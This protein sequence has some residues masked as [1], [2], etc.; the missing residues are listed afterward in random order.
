MARFGEINFAEMRIGNKV[1]T[2][3]GAGII[4]S[5]EG[6]SRVTRFGVQL[7]EPLK[8]PAA[9]KTA[10]YFKNELRIIK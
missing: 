1:E 9:F 10:Y 6:F 2:P 3:H 7:D 8:N 5:K 4:T